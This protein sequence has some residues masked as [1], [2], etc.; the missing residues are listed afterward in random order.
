[1]AVLSKLE[2]I[3]ALCKGSREIH[4]YGAGRNAK[5]VLA[6]CKNRGI[7]IDGLIVSDMAGN[8]MELSGLPVAALDGYQ[9]APGNLVLVSITKSSQAYMPIFDSLVQKRI[10][11]VIFLPQELVT[12]IKEEARR[13]KLEAFFSKGGYRLGDA[14]PTEPLHSILIMESTQG[15]C[16]WRFK[17]EAIEQLEGKTALDWFPEKSALEE[18]EGQYGAYHILH[19]L[20]GG[21]FMQE[22]SYA[23][24]AAQSHMDRRKAGGP[25]PAA[26]IPIQ[27]GAAL[28]GQHIC[29]ARDDLGDNIS[30]RNGIYSECTAL[31]WMWKNAPRTDYIGLCHYRRHFDIPEGGFAALEENSIDVVATAP[32]FVAEGIGEFFSSLTPRTDIGMLLKAIGLVRPE[33]LPTAERFLKARF[34]PP[35]NLSIMRYGLFHEYAEFVFS[36]TFKVEELYG[37]MGFHRKDRYMGY[38]VEC[39]LGIFLMHNRG[40]LRVAYTDMV[41]CP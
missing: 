27:V 38:L 30:E 28:A 10:Q 6:F 18:F 4:I 9:D 39:L 25:P 15:E 36:V 16:H 17:T 8:P 12:A 33:Y 3:A 19:S 31:Y 35:C 24:Y 14:V 23:I 1:M 21:P 7:R 26:V 20:K 5:A 22:P 34:F 13:G 41:F 32:T 2:D 40:R 29:K 11:N 37:A